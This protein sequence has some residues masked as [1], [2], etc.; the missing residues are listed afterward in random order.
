VI[1]DRFRAAHDRTYGHGYSDQPTELVNFRL[2][3][4]G[5]IAKPR[6]REISTARSDVRQAA[7]GTALFIFVHTATS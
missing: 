5:Q 1:R 7:K 3:A 2:T 6:L 4:V